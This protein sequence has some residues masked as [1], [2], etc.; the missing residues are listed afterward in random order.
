MK[1]LRR[2]WQVKTGRVETPID[3]AVPFW[4]LSFIV[5]L[6]ILVLLAWI[7]MPDDKDRKVVL[8]LDT[9]PAAEITEIE[10]AEIELDDMLSEEV[11]ADSDHSLELAASEAQMVDLIKEDPVEVDLP[12]YET[13]ELFT[14]DDFLMATAEKL[15][16]R[17]ING[18]VGE[19]VVGAS[20]AVDRIT[21]EIVRSLDQRKTLVVWM[22]DE[23][24]SL[25]T[26]REEISARFDKVYEELA[27]MQA[28]GNESFAKH[29]DTPLLTH[30]VGFGR[31]LHHLTYRPTDDL[32]EIQNAIAE[33]QTD[34]SGIENVF[35]SI[36]AIVQKY[37]SLRRINPTTRDRERNI[38]IIVV[39]DEAGDDGDQI[40]DCVRNCTKYEV[41]VFVVGI[42]A[43]FGRRETQVKWVD[44]DPEFDQTPQFALVSQGPE[45]VLP[46][47]IQ[48]DFTD[49][50]GDFDMIDSGFGPFNLT[51]LC[52]E[53]GGIYFAVHPNRK[54]G[55]S[56]GRR[57]TIRYA[58][59]IQRFF[60]PGTMRPYKPD[61]VSRE[62]YHKRLKTNK[63]RQALVDAAEFTSTGVLE[64][65]G[66]RFPRLDEARFTERVTLAQRAAARVEPALERLYGI[67]KQGEKDREREHELRWQAGYDLAMGRVLA[68]KVRATSYNA[69]LA[70]AKTSLKFSAPPD[71]ETPKNN[72]WT[73]VP[74][75]VIETGSREEKLADRAREY[76]TRVVESHPGTPWA[77][78]AG[79]ELETPIGWRWVESYQEPPR[80]RPPRENNNNNVQPNRPQPMENAM[81]RPKR[82]PPQ[83]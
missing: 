3:G 11:G 15:S 10:P 39:S 9:E 6:A 75:D 59:Y 71:D 58:A 70:M 13:G 72:V 7:I 74:E 60:D 73:L 33:I 18:S 37:K 23:S 20:G 19:A 67:L 49:Y 27:M 78:L 56:I 53:S 24:A 48:L 65:P 62:E 63:A 45:T 82:Q 54:T 36:T 51:R 4:L 47:R 83:L 1:F 21:Q 30:V 44:P 38:M 2:W 40:D 76:L 25:L 41:P 68:A 66:L 31:E 35:S 34:V 61:Y 8:V 5:H 57:E 12:T 28:A 52:F 64:A 14:N 26:Q 29:G 80:P 69:M 77:L 79:R 43:P 50:S 81:P 17:T 42:P 46:E 32:E 22:F 55:R 16:D